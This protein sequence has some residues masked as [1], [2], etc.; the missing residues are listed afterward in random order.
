MES[1]N[2]IRMKPCQGVTP[3]GIRCRNYTKNVFCREHANAA[4]A[5][6]MRAEDIV[7]GRH[8]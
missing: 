5:Q 4:M 2:E 3:Q 1:Q 8:D 6:K 7:A